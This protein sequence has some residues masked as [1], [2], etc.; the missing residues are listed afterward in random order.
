[1][2]KFGREKKIFAACRQMK[3]AISLKEASHATWE[4]FCCLEVDSVDKVGKVSLVMILVNSGK[5]RF[6][7]GM[8]ELGMKSLKSAKIETQKL[9][10]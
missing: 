1:L 10:N 6:V 5:C 2:E 7:G 3:I 8:C 9:C 4:D